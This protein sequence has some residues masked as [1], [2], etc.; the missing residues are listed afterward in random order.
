MKAVTVRGVGGP[1]VVHV[2]DVPEP[3]PG[4]GEVRVRVRAAGVNRADILQRQGSYPAPP[5]SPPDLLGLE[6][7]GEVESLGEGARLWRV[8]QRVY[9]ICGGG[10][11]AELVVAHE[12]ALAAIPDNLDFAA[13]GA[14]PEVFIT[15][16]DALFT[17]AQLQPGESLLIHAVGSGIGTTAVQLARVAGARTFGTSRTNE[18][19]ERAR[20]LGL[21]DGVP[22]AG[23]AD[24]VRER[25]GG[26]GVDVI[27]DVVGG[28][29]LAENLAALALKGR[30][31]ILAHLGGADAPLPVAKL[32]ARRARIIGTVLRA[33]PL[34][35][36]IA[37]TQAFARL[38]N[39]LLADGTVRPVVDRT[40]ALA[41]AAAAQVYMESNASFGKVV[42][43]LP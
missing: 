40:F 24:A 20:S 4:A 35:E 43:T 26:R 39:P 13:A 12:R 11:Q 22:A 32:M 10:G 18:K 17:Q 29:Y 9:G 5:G 8:G 27:L 34:E 23:F 37:A 28:G 30:L 14:V 21:D 31:V 41:D 2:A 15:V 6:F 3:R 16:H 1:E 36:K 25:T 33:R 19:L 42:L 38:V 7:A